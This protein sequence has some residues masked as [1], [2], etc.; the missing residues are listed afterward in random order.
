MGWDG[1]N[2]PFV[3]SRNRHLT[4]SAAP[5]GSSHAELRET[6]ANTY[7]EGP[8]DSASA[9]AAIFHVAAGRGCAKAIHD[10]N[11]VAGAYA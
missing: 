1:G 8:H 11:H 7:P 10:A 5:S 4:A 6:F 3:P 9:G 2:K